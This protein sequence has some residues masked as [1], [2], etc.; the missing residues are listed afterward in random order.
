MKGSAAPPLV[1]THCHLALLEERGLLDAALEGAAMAGVEQIVGIGLD[2]ED[3][4]RNRVI[5]EAH[6]N[7][8]FTVGWH[9]HQRR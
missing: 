1:D 5:A 3:S 8:W 6:E 9:P 4:D 2:I 7:V